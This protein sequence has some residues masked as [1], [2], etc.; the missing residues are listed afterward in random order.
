MRKQRFRF[1]N[2]L[3]SLDSTTISLCLEMFS[4]GKI[5][6]GEKAASRPT[7]CWT[8]TTTLPRYV[9]ITEARRSDVK[10]AAAFPAQPRLDRRDGSRLQRL[11][12]FRKVDRTRES[13]SSRA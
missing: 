12:T 13:I 7:C 2:K 8:T 5:P 3:L 1:K 6:P 11:R 10:M 9:L 4:V